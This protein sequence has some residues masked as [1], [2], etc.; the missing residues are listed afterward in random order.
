M[1]TYLSDSQPRPSVTRTCGCEY[2]PPYLTQGY[3]PT[4]PKPNQNHSKS[5][6]PLT[7][8]LVS[9][10][11][12][13]LASLHES[14]TSTDLPALN[15]APIAPARL[16]EGLPSCRTHAGLSQ[17]FYILFPLSSRC[18]YAIELRKEGGDWGCGVPL[19]VANDHLCGY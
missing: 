17:P 19:G 4:T 13:H 14:E 8:S 18:S 2:P 16:L 12:F 9:L 6:V 11:A 7:Y 1:N 15:R 5:F 3:L 10:Q